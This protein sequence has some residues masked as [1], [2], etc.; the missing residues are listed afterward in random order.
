M[1]NKI[2][3]PKSV[4]IR[5]RDKNQN[6][7]PCTKKNPCSFILCLSKDLHGLHRLLIICKKQ[8]KTCQIFFK[9][10]AC[11]LDPQCNFLYGYF[12]HNLPEDTIDMDVTVCTLKGIHTFRKITTP[13]HLYGGHGVHESDHSLP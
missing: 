8:Y 7:K 3:L 4:T 6:K 9:R 10:M 5:F 11:A 1:G 2:N 12:T 13:K